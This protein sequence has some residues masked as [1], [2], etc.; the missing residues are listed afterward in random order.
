[1]ANYSK[2][3]NSKSGL[4]SLKGLPEYIFEQNLKVDM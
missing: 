4:Q 3:L 2:T 1:M